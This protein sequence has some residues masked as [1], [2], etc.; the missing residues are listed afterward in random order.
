MLDYC[1][2]FKCSK[3]KSC[4]VPAVLSAWL[5][6]HFLSSNSRRVPITTGA[7]RHFA[8]Q[9]VHYPWASPGV[10]RSGG[11]TT[12]F[13]GGGFD[14]IVIR[15]GTMFE[16]PWNHFH[17]NDLV[18]HPIETSNLQNGWLAGSRK[19]STILFWVCFQNV[20]DAASRVTFCA[21]LI[22]GRFR[23]WMSPGWYSISQA[24]F[25]P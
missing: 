18:R 16:T 7:Q 6:W 9:R 17:G 23:R 19:I 20:N 15:G 3:V 13:G 8:I 10:L 5:L 2:W 21:N 4:N 22:A 12:I 11:K 1:I 25:G 14:L 24:P